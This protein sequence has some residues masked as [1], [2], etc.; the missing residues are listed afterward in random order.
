MG[1]E[2]MHA[3]LCNC[4]YYLFTYFLFLRSCFVLTDTIL[5]KNFRALSRHAKSINHPEESLCGSWS[6]PLI[7]IAP[8]L[9]RRIDP[10][11]SVFP[12]AI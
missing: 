9:L 12:R 3:F 7:R 2:N 11:K 5:F 1:I 10:V 8:P 4:Y 6:L